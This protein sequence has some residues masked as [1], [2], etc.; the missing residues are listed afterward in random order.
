M[1]SKKVHFG[2]KNFIQRSIVN[3]LTTVVNDLKGLFVGNDLELI[4]Q[5]MISDEVALQN[6]NVQNMFLCLPKGIRD[7]VETYIEQRYYIYR[8]K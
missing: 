8:Q 3:K 4:K 1:K 2:A 7:E 5:D 6:E